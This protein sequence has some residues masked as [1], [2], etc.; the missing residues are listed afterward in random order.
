MDKGDRVSAINMEYRNEGMTARSQ[1]EAKTPRLDASLSP[2]LIPYLHTLRRTARAILTSQQE[3]RG[4]CKDL[5]RKVR[6]V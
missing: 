3:S 2:S 6:H 4:L 5:Y 1:G